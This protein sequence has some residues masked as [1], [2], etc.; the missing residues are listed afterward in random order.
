MRNYPSPQE[1]LRIIAK[2]KALMQELIETFLKPDKDQEMNRLSK[3][4]GGAEVQRM[5]ENVRRNLQNR[6]I[7]NDEEILYRDYLKIYR[8]FGGERAFLDFRTFNKLNDEF[9][10]LYARKN[11]GSDLSMAE[12]ERLEEL[13]DLMLKGSQYWEDITP[14][15]PP[16]EMPVMEDLPGYSPSQASTIRLAEGQAPVCKKDGFPLLKINN[17]LKCVAEYLD[18][19]IGQKTIIDV[20]QSDKT[21]YLVF[22]NGHKLPLL[23]PCCNGSLEITDLEEMR[24]KIIRQRLVSMSIASRVYEDGQEYDELVLEFSDKEVPSETVDLSVSFEVAL[25]LE[26]PIMCRQRSRTNRERDAKKKK[27]SRKKKRRGK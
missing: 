2:R 19:C 24:R 11:F 4:Y 10:D 5:L 12:E 13:D 22:S 18:D 1:R 20:V 27:R 3:K 25:E 17:Q 26:H 7:E 9:A 23:C 21:T 16:D 8:R 14:E 6:N 15:D